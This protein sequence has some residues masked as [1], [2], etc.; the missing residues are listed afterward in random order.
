MTIQKTMKL[1]VLRSLEELLTEKISINVIQI[2]E[3][4]IALNN[5]IVTSPINIHEK[6]PHKNF[7]SLTFNFSEE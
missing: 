1:L 6:L 7:S 4:I 3:S 2:V 5:R